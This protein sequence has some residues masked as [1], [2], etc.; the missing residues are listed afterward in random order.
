MDTSGL[1]TLFV[2][3]IGFGGTLGFLLGYGLKKVAT[4][5]LKILALISGLFMLGLT[6]LASIGVITVN[7]NAFSS[8]VDSGF[9]GAIAGL[10]G[11]LAFL[12][13]VLP[14][15]GSFSLGFYL[16]AKKG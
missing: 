15:G 9:A 3:Q 5:V 8:A 4:V 14:I 2:T 7:F 12:G 13:Q 1:A 16:G 10:V 11:S 6:W